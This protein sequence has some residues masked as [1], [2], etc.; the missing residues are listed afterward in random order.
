[1]AGKFEHHR[2]P[3]CGKH[4]NGYIAS[5][6]LAGAWG[7][8]AILGGDLPENHDWWCFGCSVEHFQSEGR[9]RMVG[10]TH[11][12]AGENKASLGPFR[13]GTGGGRR[14]IRSSKGLY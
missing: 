13:F 8:F 14:V 5:R 10:E 1:M 9:K 11:V 6:K 7:L 12:R 2:C 3:K 4:G